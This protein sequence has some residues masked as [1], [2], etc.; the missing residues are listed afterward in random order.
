M[1]CLNNIN[2][3][4]KKKNDLR[5]FFWGFRDF[6]MIKFHHIEDEKIAI[7]CLNSVI[8]INSVLNEFVFLIFKTLNEKII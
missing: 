2:N 6:F 4:G 1:A 8:G 5:S 3:L 7:E